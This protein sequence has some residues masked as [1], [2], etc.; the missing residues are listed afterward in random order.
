VQADTSKV[1]VTV[2]DDGVG[3]SA[4]GMQPGRFGLRGLSER[5]A[6]LGGSFEVGASAPHG[7]RLS[8]QIPLA[9]QA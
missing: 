4:Q 6:H 3:M 7:V 8:A 2:A 1:V 9:P 5:V